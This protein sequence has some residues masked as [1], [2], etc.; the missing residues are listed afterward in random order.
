MAT[1]KTSVSLSSTDLTTGTLSSST[2]KDL[3]VTKGGILVKELDG[4]AV[5]DAVV[6]LAAADH[7]EGTKV[8]IKNTHA[9]NTVNV[10]FTASSTSELKIPAGAWAFFS[11]KAA[12]DMK[13]WPS[14]NDT[15]VEYGT[16]K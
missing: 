2:T 11:W 16:F 1:L 8:Y 10:Q 5:G 14:A 9:S 4:T 7:T 3:T 12:V 13:V 6:L 15:F